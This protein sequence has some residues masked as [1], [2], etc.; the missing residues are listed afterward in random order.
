MTR[1][2]F[3]DT[4]KYEV[5]RFDQRTEQSR[6]KAWLL[7]RRKGVGGSDVAAIL[8]ISPWAT[9]YQVWLDKTGRKEPEDIS[10]SLAV[11]MGVNNE[12]LLRKR[13]KDDHPGLIVVDGTN[14]SLV[15]RERPYM[16]A[17]LD[18]LLYDPKTDS[19]GILEIKCVSADRE[20]S[21]WVDYRGNYVIPTYYMAQ[22]THYMVVTGYQ[23]GYV[24]VAFGNRKDVDI[25][26]T[27][28]EADITAVTNVVED[29][30]TH[31]VQTDTPPQL[32]TIDDVKEAY[33]ED[34]GEIIETQ[35]AQFDELAKKY[36][37]YQA[38]EAENK[39]NKEEIKTQLAAMIG[40]SQGL[41]SGHYKVTYKTSHRKERTVTYPATTVRTMRVTNIKEQE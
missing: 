16:H 35:D 23:W 24:R 31:Y 39:R 33:P 12:P 34:D 26:F 5:V 19:Y 6:R 28:D 22:V 13:F 8:G 37:E 40:T 18:G 27:R 2:Y 30:W 4:A 15:S 14:K 10:G 20:Y 11:Q 29:F 36:S 38:A 9:A 7:E 1:V 25:R 32:R 17:S 41:I 3:R 21:D